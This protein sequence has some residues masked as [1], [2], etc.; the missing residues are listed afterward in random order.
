MSASPSVQIDAPNNARSFNKNCPGAT[1]RAGN[2]PKLASHTG[3][4]D[5][6]KLRVPKNSTAASALPVAEIFTE[7]G[8]AAIITAMAFNH[9]WPIAP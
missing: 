4:V 2:P 1:D 9:W 8:L 6:M 5:S 7:I 3:G